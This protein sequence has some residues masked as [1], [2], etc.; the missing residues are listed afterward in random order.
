MMDA[1]GSERGTP[2]ASGLGSDQPVTAREAVDKMVQAGMLDDLMNQVDSG[3]LQLTGEGGFLPELVRRVLEAGLQAELTDHL[4][5]EKHDRAGHGSGNSRNGYTPKRL[6]S[7]VGDIELATPRDRLGQLRAAAGAEGATPGR[8]AVGHDHQ[9]YAGGMTIRDIQAHLERT[10]GTELSHETIS[11]ITD[12]VLEEVKAWQA[13][14]LEAVYPILYL[15]ALVVKV[16]ESHQVRNKAA[17]IA[18]G[19]DVDGIK[20]VLGIWVQTI[21]G[22]EV[23][24]RGA[25]RAP[26]PRRGRCV[27]RLLRRADRLPGGDRGDLAEDCG[28][29]LCGASDPGLDAVH[30]LQRPQGR[31][32]G[33][34][35]HLHRRHRSRRGPGA[36]HLRGLQLG[37]EVSGHGAGVAGRLGTVHPVSG[38]PAGGAE[39]HLHH[40]RS[41]R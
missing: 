9:L 7:E 39:D 2:E 23:L 40:Q 21:R 25:R 12:A 28:P 13:R 19:V 5:Y 29:D 10:L 11:N 1:V 38:V 31:R 34:A 3:D 8:R 24:G 22:R 6:G 16:K 18:V 30:L 17:H 27:D 20:H 37:Q 26:Q 4:G 15:D 33:A 41:S 32:G 35:A 14:P 36:G